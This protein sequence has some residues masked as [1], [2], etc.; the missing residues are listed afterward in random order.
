MHP[1]ALA[2]ADGRDG[3]GEAADSRGF[4]DPLLG[5][6]HDE[7][8]TWEATIGMSEKGGMND[9]EFFKYIM[10]SIRL[11][12]PDMSNKPGKRVLLKEFLQ[13]DSTGVVHR[14]VYL[15]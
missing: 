14:I 9:K 12:Y 8:K 3:Q 2:T 6:G 13:A 5:Y 11:L 7:E 15:S 4:F 1:P 10:T